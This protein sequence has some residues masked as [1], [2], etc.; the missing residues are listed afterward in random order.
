MHSNFI[1]FF[2]LCLLILITSKTVIPVPIPLAG[3]RIWK[4]CADS[5]LNCITCHNLLESFQTTC[6]ENHLTK[7]ISPVVMPL[8]KSQKKRIYFE[9]NWD[10]CI[11]STQSLTNSFC[12]VFLKLSSLQAELET[13]K[14]Q[15]K[16][17]TDTSNSLITSLKEELSKLTKMTEEQFTEKEEKLAI[18]IAELDKVKK[19]LDKVRKTGRM[20]FTLPR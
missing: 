20:F 15:F 4:G 19:E 8:I 12:F 11:L 5:A 2:F 9:N 13:L 14:S 6:C 10:I 3:Q 16:K 18:Q 1:W 7:K 17:S